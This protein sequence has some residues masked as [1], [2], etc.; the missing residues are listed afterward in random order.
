MILAQN[1]YQVISLVMSML[2]TIHIFPGF[3]LYQ[4]MMFLIWVGVISWVLGGLFGFINF[5]GGGGDD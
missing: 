2:K 5:R 1:I 4:A 3:T